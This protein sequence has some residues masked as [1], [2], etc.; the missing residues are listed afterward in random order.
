MIDVEVV[1]GDGNVERSRSRLFALEGGRCQWVHL[2]QRWAGV[3][4]EGWRAHVEATDQ[5][6][7][8]AKRV[9]EERVG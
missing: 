9:L 4:D 2:A 8:T 6:L 1:A 7:E 5:D 3:T